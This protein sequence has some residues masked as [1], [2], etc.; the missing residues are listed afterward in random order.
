MRCLLRWFPLFFLMTSLIDDL[1][2]V[3][4]DEKSVIRNP[5]GDQTTVARHPQSLRHGFTCAVSFI[6]SVQ[7]WANGKEE[8]KVPSWM[9]ARRCTSDFLNL[10]WIELMLSVTESFSF[11]IRAESKN[12][13][14]SITDWGFLWFFATIIFNNAKPL[15]DMAKIPIL[16]SCWRSFP[17]CF[18]LQKNYGRQPC[19]FYLGKPQLQELSISICV[20]TN[21]FFLSKTNAWNPNAAPCF[22][23]PWR[24]PIKNLPISGVFTN[25]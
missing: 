8:T 16:K 24:S 20:A 21:H 5:Q 17:L 12:G 1:D 2:M 10:L 7:W 23:F 18:M 6:C 3:E 19:Q 25:P 13:I 11:S 14:T 4:S 9:H 15:S 22:L